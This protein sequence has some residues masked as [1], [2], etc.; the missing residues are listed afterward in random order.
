M[1]IAFANL[2]GNSGKT[3]LSSALAAVKGLPLIRIE[4]V[5]STFTNADI[6]IQSRQDIISAIGT[7]HSLRDVGQSAILDIGSSDLGHILSEFNTEYNSLK[8][9]VDFWVI[10]CVNEVKQIADTKKTIMKLCAERINPQ[11]IVVVFNRVDRQENMANL[12]SLIDGAKNVGYFV[13]DNYI[14]KFSLFNAMNQES[15]S[16]VDIL[17][18]DV[19]SDD[20][21]K[22]K[23]MEALKRKDWKSL[24]TLGAI[25]EK[26]NMAQT[27][28]SNLEM[29]FQSTP[30]FKG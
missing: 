17:S 7:I 18:T 21:I 10:P 23:Q 5:N 30:I 29:V 14:G 15:I 22:Q 28:A 8:S 3:T 26:K 24:T 11:Q 6:E 20:S 12:S 1:I 27:I 9:L 2:S 25:K 13:A 19:E 16:I 4:S